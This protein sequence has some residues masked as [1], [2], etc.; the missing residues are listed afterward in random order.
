MIDALRYAVEGARRALNSAPPVMTSA[1]R[2]WRCA[3]NCSI[4]AQPRRAVTSRTWRPLPC[5]RTIPTPRSRSRTRATTSSEVFERAM[6]RFDI[7][8][9]PQLEQRALALAAGASSASPAR[10]GKATS[11]TSSTMR[12]SSR[13]TSR[14]TGCGRFT[15]TTTRTGSCPTSGRL[16]ARATRTARPRSTGCTARIRTSSRLNRRATMRS[17]RAR[18]AGSARTADERMGRPL[19]QGQRPAADQPGLCDR[20]RRPAGVLRS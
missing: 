12:S 14:R 3:A 10:S 4:A 19:R 15:A 18:P 11:A 6:R 9:T 13:S 5:L 20:R 17:S 8:V 2:G 7:A 16:A 1:S